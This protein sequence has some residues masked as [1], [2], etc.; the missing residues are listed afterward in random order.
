MWYDESCTTNKYIYCNI[1]VIYYEYEK[2]WINI[3]VWYNIK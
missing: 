1:T 2:I 3:V